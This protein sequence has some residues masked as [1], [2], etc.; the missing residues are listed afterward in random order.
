MRFCGRLNHFAA[1]LVHQYLV[2]TQMHKKIKTVLQ[3]KLKPILGEI[4]L[5]RKLPAIRLKLEY[6]II[7]A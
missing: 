6:E 3:R 7:V 5:F 2:K 4:L 1:V